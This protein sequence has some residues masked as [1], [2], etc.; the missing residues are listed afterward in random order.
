MITQFLVATLFTFAATAYDGKP[1]PKVSDEKPKE[2][3]E[4]GIDEKLGQSLD[5]SLKVTNEDGQ[6]VTLGSFFD[7]KTPV[8]LSL[9]Y[10][11]CP[12]LC[13]LHLNVVVSTLKDLD[14]SVGN[15]FKVVAVSFDPKET[16]DVAKQKKANYL[17]E[18]NRKGTENGWAFATASQESIDSL[19]KQVGFKYKWDD[20][21]Q[22]WAHASA[23]IVVTPEGKISRYLHGVHFEPQSFKLAL[24][25]ATN[26][27][28]GT[29]VEKMVWYCFKY[30]PKQSKYTLYAFRLVQL[31]GGLIILVLSAVLI[32]FWI[33]SRRESGAA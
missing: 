5:L 8:I 20:Q 16:S 21:N 32:P 27:K 14:W 29:L 9:V 11:S 22:E 17:K 4:I 12:S 3:Q 33:R 26:G 31:G 2:L 15:K 24:G 19:T 28:I 23:A 18:Y 30:D 10:Y 7:G 6:V 1:A 13:N 25:E